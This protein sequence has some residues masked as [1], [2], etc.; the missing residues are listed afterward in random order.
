MMSAKERAKAKMRAKAT[1]A[2]AARLVKAPDNALSS[3]TLP[4][5]DR[6]F[7]PTPTL[8]K[9]PD[10]SLSVA[11]PSIMTTTSPL[12]FLESAPLPA[13]A[14]KVP[15]PEAVTVTEQ[16]MALFDDVM[17]AVDDV[18]TVVNTGAG[19]VTSVI[20]TING[21]PKGGSAKERAKARMRE[22]AGLAAAKVKAKRDA[23]MNGGATPDIVPPSSS[24]SSGGTNWG[25]ALAG[26]G[27][28]IQLL[29]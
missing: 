13:T 18:Q 3:S 24:S 7:S 17:N 21:T 15:A 28:A 26:V 25:L 5:L 16:T 14:I 8:V 6:V 4:F 20:D 22:K 2:V 29:K 11:L 1:A 10:N 19:A 27:L 12:P 9:A 23:A